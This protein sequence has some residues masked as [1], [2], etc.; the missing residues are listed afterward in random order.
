[1]I[2]LTNKLFPST[3]KFYSDY[4][5]MGD[6]SQLIILVVLCNYWNNKEF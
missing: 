1:M 3:N 2:Y 4:E 6:L 5:Q